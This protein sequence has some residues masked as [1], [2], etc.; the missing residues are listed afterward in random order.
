MAT[1][2]YTVDGVTESHVKVTVT[3]PSGDTFKHTL[4]VGPFENVPDSK[5]D[6]VIGN[7][8]KGEAKRRVNNQNLSDADL[9]DNGSFD[10]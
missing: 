1:I 2:K 5:R 8:L 6:E 3:L 9:P 7:M 10:V 4:P